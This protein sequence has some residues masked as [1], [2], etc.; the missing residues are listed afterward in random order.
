M[1]KKKLVITV[2]IVGISI[3]FL[4]FSLQNNSETTYLEKLSDR[5]NTYDMRVREMPIDDPHVKKIQR[6]WY[7]NV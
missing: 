3:P 5:K 2:L 4:I 6:V 7:L 1:Q